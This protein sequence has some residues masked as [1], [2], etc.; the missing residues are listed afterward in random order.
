MCL[1]QG[2]WG[3][4]LSSSSVEEETDFFKSGASSM[5]VTRYSSYRFIM[6]L[7]LMIPGIGPLGWWRR[8]EKPVE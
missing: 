8:L 4:I 6:A 3:A 7:L 5:D 2:I 1:L